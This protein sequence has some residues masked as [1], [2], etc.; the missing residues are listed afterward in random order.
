MSAI[1]HTI[2]VVCEGRLAKPEALA[3]L[4]SAL[5]ATREGSDA[6]PTLRLPSGVSID[7]TVPKFG[8]DLPLTLDLY[9]GVPRETLHR[10]AEEIIDTI[11]QHTGWSCSVFPP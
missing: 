8:E 5:D 7:I 9:A 1:E 4:Q 6:F 11:Y 3:L 2:S 10:V